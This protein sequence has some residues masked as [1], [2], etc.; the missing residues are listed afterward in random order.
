MENYSILKICSKTHIALIVLASL[1][2][3]ACGSKDTIKDDNTS[4]PPT[5]SNPSGF[6]TS[7]AYQVPHDAP[8][9]VSSDSTQL[10]ALATFAWQEFIALNWPS[11]YTT[12]T[13]TRGKPDTTQTALDFALPGNNG[14]LVWETYK[15]R[16]EIYPMANSSGDYPNYPSS[17]NNVPQ[18]DYPGVDGG[19]I[20]EC[21]AYNATT[22]MWAVNTQS[23][24]SSVSLFNNLDETSEINLCTLFTDGD[25]NAPGAAPASSTAL[26][27]GL[28]KQPRRFIYEAKAN[29]VM[30]DYIMSNNYYKQTIRATA[31]Q[32][33]YTAVRNN[34]DGGIAPC[35]TPDPNNPIICF[36]PGVSGSNGSEGTILVKATWRQLTMDEYNSGRYL[37]S[38]I[39]RYRNPDP[40]NA[41]KFCY[42]TIPA[43]PSP[44]M[45]PTTLPYGLVGLHIIHKTTNY[46][47]YVFATF[48]QVDNLNSGTPDSSLFYYNR[49][50]VAPI[51]PG[52]QTI[53]SR[54][55]PIPDEMNSVT[56]QV[57][58]Q[59]R[60][61]LAAN[62][63]SDSV[64]LYYKLIGVQGAATNPSNTEGTDYFLANIVT[65][66]NEI[67]RSFSGTLDNT[68]GTI[69]P[70]NTNLRKGH[71]AYTGGGCKGC[72]GNAQVGP[73][74]QKGMPSPAQST[75]I[76]S[77]FSFI[78]QNAPFDGVPD[79]INQPLLKSNT[80]ETQT[81]A[82]AI[83]YSGTA[84]K[85]SK[86]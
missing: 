12:T 52:K 18:Y 61:L 50:D 16:V 74:V 38:P 34:G 9:P 64:W 17:F 22:G 44:T 19:S 48:E 32:N 53:T 55:H 71:T 78:T 85:T 86:Q 15:H 67:L 83:N 6:F 46:P 35:P 84:S 59:L 77:D 31:Q 40:S 3:Y 72:H 73:L 2:I 80:V 26:Y 25:P 10:T 62:G 21:G 27:M 54:A 14:E 63:Q 4:I 76:A 37:T 8:A 7:T 51:S 30:S 23:T 42:E 60:Q 70:Q 47:T 1:F 58:L 29:Q 79:A 66:T 82:Q 24:L 65:E 33:T 49:N 5:T 11:N 13:P 56:A 43:T 69:N 57:H 41:K 36:R 75:L 68:T 45:S 81:T 28:P 39:I 20:P